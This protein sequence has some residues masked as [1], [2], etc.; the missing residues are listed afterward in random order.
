MKKKILLVTAILITAGVGV[1]KYAYKEHRN[2]ETEKATFVV[3]ASEMLDAFSTDAD[4]ASAKY[5]NKT[6]EVSGTVT[7]QEANNITIDNSI[8]AQ[9]T[10]TAVKAA[11]AITF[12]GRCLGYDEL[13]EEIK[14]DQCTIVE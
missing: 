13:L 11:G 4:A 1:Y 8:Y 14:F 2:I 9:F 7:A 10:D 12:K 5:T 6:I 3:T